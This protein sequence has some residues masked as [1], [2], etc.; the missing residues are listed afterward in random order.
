MKKRIE[1]EEGNPEDYSWYFDLRKYGSVPHSG[2]GVG[3]ERVLR[4]ICSMENIKDA[5]A[6][7]RTMSRNKP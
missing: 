6:F 2:Y 5:I 4:W 3:V 1:K 7:P